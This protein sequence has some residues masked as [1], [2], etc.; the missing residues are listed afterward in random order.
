MRQAALVYENSSEAMLVTDK[1]NN[2]IAINP[3]F[4]LITGYSM[5]DLEG[6]T[7]EILSSGR[8]DSEFYQAMWESLDKTGTWSGEIWNRRKNGEA[9]AEWLTI[10]TIYDEHKQISKRIAL[11][12]DITR[13][14]VAEALILQQANYDNLT[15]LPNSRFLLEHLKLELSRAIERY[16]TGGILFINLDR[17][18]E[19]NESLGHDIG[20]QLLKDVATR[21]K[22]ALSDS[23]F[24]ARYSADEFV[25]VQSQIK[26]PQQFE[27]V[28]Y[29]LLRVLAEPFVFSTDPI[30]ITASI[31]ISLFPIDGDDAS[32]LLN[33]ADKAMTAAKQAGGI[34]IITL[35]R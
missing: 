16:E 3:A 31:G 14:K 15:H 5:D 4:T 21:L 29:N 1:R 13:K 26:S 25:V 27:S 23:D 9:Y 30:Y 7:P 12:T 11:F 34:A 22:H 24:I 8:H 17:F 33:N 2:I 28:A 32:L 19:I 6:H 10:N 18:K 35:N 20:D